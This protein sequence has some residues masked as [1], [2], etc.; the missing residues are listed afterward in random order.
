MALAK[1]SSR[2]IVVDDVEYRWRVRRNDRCCEYHLGTLGYVV[3][4][5]A[6]PGTLLVV[7]TG[8]P[9]VMAPGAVRAELVLPREVAAG[10]RAALSNGWTPDSAGSPFKLRLSAA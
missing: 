3:E 1:K 5:A 6:R 4:E 8:R 9:A 10:V 7:D 2:R